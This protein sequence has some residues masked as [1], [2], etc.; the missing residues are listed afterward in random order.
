VTLR[1][2]DRTARRQAPR[3][4]Q[5]IEQLEH[6]RILAY[7]RDSANQLIR[8]ASE[9]AK[10]GTIEDLQTASKLYMQ[11]LGLAPD[12][13]DIPELYQKVAGSIAEH[14]HRLQLDE[15]QR[16][17]VTVGV[18]FLDS[19][20]KAVDWN[21]PLEKEL[22]ERQQE[23]RFLLGNI[24]A[25][26]NAKARGKI[27]ETESAIDVLQRRIAENQGRAKKFLEQAIAF[28]PT[29]SVVREAVS[30]F[31]AERLLYYDKI[32]N[33]AEAHATEGLLRA[34]HDGRYQSL[35]QNK[36]TLQ[37][38]TDSQDVQ[39]RLLYE[40]AERTLQEDPHGKIWSLAAGEKI[41]LLAG[42]Y[43][44][45]TSEG[46]TR[47]LYVRRGET[48]VISLPKARRIPAG[49]IIIPGGSVFDESGVLLEVVPSFALAQYEIT[50]EEYLQ[51]LNDPAITQRI[52]EKELAGDLRLVPRLVGKSLIQYSLEKGYF[53]PGM[54]FNR[55]Y[56][57][58]APISCISGQDVLAFI[59][60]KTQREGGEVMWR[61]P[62][63]SEWQLAA[64]SGDERLYPW[65]MRADLTY[66]A[67]THG[68]LSERWCYI[69][70]GSF[71]RDRTVHGIFDLSGSVSEFVTDSGVI[72]QAAGGNHR[73]RQIHS[74]IVYSRRDVSDSDTEAG[75][76]FRL[77][78]SLPND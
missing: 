46:I 14:N 29:S 44:L 71:P 36:G 66:S 35:L 4:K 53:F 27:H 77:A 78:L 73:D 5:G 11:A 55:P 32:G 72:R 75:V 63:S 47:A 74:F 64:Q 3:I 50:C 68:S 54:A 39:C 65:G 37:L 10:S 76:G 38:D 33:H 43:V 22:S 1:P 34:Y 8:E 18:G 21:K 70:V 61:L 2:E 57:P 69:A 49:T 6:E 28:A 17:K 41:E 15:E 26:D 7:K 19:A 13:K 16:R 67:T 20:K 51:F 12:D 24:R 62:T 48:T 40:G 25:N 9:R 56:L 60:W 45:M 59:S 58:R 30:D 42:R 52:K 23:L 31:Y